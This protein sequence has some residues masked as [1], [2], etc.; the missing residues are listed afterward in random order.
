MSDE[1]K[2][3]ITP[4][5]RKK[6]T[7]ELRKKHQPL[8]D[9]LGVPDAV[10]IPKMAHYVPDL[11]GLHMGFFESELDHGGDVY[12]EKVSKYIESE[13]ETRT[14]YKITYNPFFKD[15][16]ATSEP[17]ASGSVR[18]FIPVDEMEIVRAPEKKAKPKSD[19]IDFSFTKSSGG[20]GMN[21]KLADASLRDFA[22]IMLRVPNSEHEW[23]NEMIKKAK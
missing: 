18:Y 2:V 11:E 17:T 5:E 8:F 22:A 20:T 3:K 21:P 23:L 7:A 1:V 12:T 6:R 13:D 16:Y 15:E 14:L 9:A 4:Q 19:K 10:F